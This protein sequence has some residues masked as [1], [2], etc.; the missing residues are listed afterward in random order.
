VPTVVGKHATSGEIV[1]IEGA[2]P[3]PGLAQRLG[4]NPPGG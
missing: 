2:L 1:T 3:A 4:L